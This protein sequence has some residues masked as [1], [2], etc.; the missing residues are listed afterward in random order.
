MSIDESRRTELLIKQLAASITVL[1]IEHD[2]EMIMGISDSITVLQ[3]GRVLAQGSPA[4]IRADAKVQDA[5]L[6]GHSETE[7]AG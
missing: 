6:G 4:D 7:I 3:G 1:I 2:M 5:Y